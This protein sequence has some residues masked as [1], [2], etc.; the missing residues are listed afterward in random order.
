[1]FTFMA[2]R[3][4]ASYDI[5]GCADLLNI[6]DPITITQ[7]KNGAAI[8]ATINLPLYDRCRRRLAPYE[9]QDVAADDA[10]NAAA[11]TE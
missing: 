4:A 9:S 7:D 8:K 11:T 10:A 5:L 6:P 2:Q 3:F 1:M